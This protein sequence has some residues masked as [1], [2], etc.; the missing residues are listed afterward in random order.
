MSLT[1]SPYAAPLPESAVPE[2]LKTWVPWVMHGHEMLACPKAYN[3][4]PDSVQR[5]C[6]WPSL[7]KLDAD[8]NGATFRFDVQVF[9]APTWIILPGEPGLWPQEVRRKDATLAVAAKDQRPAVELP[10]GSHTITGRLPWTEMPQDIR[11]PSD[12]GLIELTIN[13]RIARRAPDPHGRV[14]LR[15]KPDSPQAND[16]VRVRT[17]RLIDDDIPMRVTTHYDISVS[18][19]PRALTLPAALLPEFVADS[20][21]SE[22]PARLQED[23][24][25][26]VQARA[27]NWTL[28]VRGRLMQPTVHLALP[29]GLP[30]EWWS[31]LA[32]NDLRVITAEGLTV[33]DPK[34]VPI[35]DAWRAFPTYQIKAGQAL[36]LIESRRGNPQPGADQLHL[37]RQIWLDF[38]GDGYTLQ[39]H[40]KGSL[41]RTWRLDMA[42]PGVLGRA[43]I[44]GEDQ[45]ITRLAD[46]EG[47]A[48]RRG[49]LEMSADSR[50]EHGVRRL[51]ATGWQTDFNAA[52]IQL[53]LPPGWRLLHASGV[54][55]AQGTWVAGWT[56]WDFFFV[57]LTA[58]AAGKLLG[59]NM[60]VLF[61][62]ALTLTWHMPGAP[63]AL[64]LTVLALI[65]LARVLPAGTL[66]TATTR[67]SKLFAAVLA[68]WLVPYGIDQIRIAIY[69][70]LEHPWQSVAA[71]LS[72]P[73][74]RLDADEEHAAV[75]SMAQER[76]APEPVLRKAQVPSSP[77]MA[78]LENRL[79][80]A[81]DTID[82]NTKIQTGPGLPGWRWNAYSLLWQGPVPSAQEI[83]LYLMPPAGSVL[84][85]IG[86]FIL[87]VASLWGLLTALPGW[88]RRQ[89]GASTTPTAPGAQ[90]VALMLGATTLA[91]AL[92]AAPTPVLAQTVPTEMPSP[93]LLD[94][95]RAKL[96]QPAD[97]LPQCADMTRLHVQT[98]GTQLQLRLETHVLALGQIPLPGQG[99]NWQPDSVHV[100]DRPATLRR[101]TAGILWAA[102]PAGVHQ[103]VMRADVHQAHSIDISLPMAVRA[104]SVQAPGWRVSGL[105]ARGLPSGALSLSRDRAAHETAARIEGMPSDALPPF[106]VIERV[107]HLGLRWT[108]QTRVYRAAP[109]RAPIIARIPLLKGEAVNSESVRTE[110]GVAI[111]QLGTAQSEQF[112]STVQEAEALE[113]VSGQDSHQ[114]EHW[115]LHPSAQ[116]HVAPS[117]IAPIRYIDPATNRLA[118]LWRPWPGER[119]TLTLR[120]PTGVDGQTLT[121]DQQNLSF[122]PGARATDVHSI[123]QLRT[124][125]GGNHE[126]H[127]PAD[128]T[129]LGVSLNGQA[130]PIQPQNGVLSIPVTPGAHTVQVHW[131]E[132]RGI[133][134]W[135][136]TS[137][138]KLGAAGVNAHTH[139]NVPRD[140]IVLAVSGPNIGPAVLFWGVL[141]A[142]IIIAIA[143]AR[144]RF[145]PLGTVAWFLLGIGVMQTSLV[146][147]AIVAGWFFALAARQ[148]FVPTLTALQTRWA[149]LTANLGQLV[150]V[151]WTLVA[152]AFL[153]DAIRVGLLGYP[154]MRVGG[155][156]SSAY[157]LN[158]YQDRFSDAPQTAGV[159]SAPVW[160]Y[161][162]LMLAW[163]L[164]L[165][166]ALLKWVRWAWG[167]F[168]A[169]GYWHTANRVRATTTD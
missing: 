56:L 167:C 44:D 80:N 107:L 73:K 94:E 12:T 148:R 84:L 142:L 113:W 7:L 19:N 126:V 92:L 165:S 39:D 1:A 161:R 3:S 17:A 32:H 163:A 162:L 2:P 38:D 139:I 79:P 13:G 143:L 105:D 23:G 55:Q 85:R 96:T 62:A 106:V 66:L 9:G 168:S 59:R 116:W 11:L 133:G 95:L 8:D 112:V 75:S 6:V 43:A 48:L 91:A 26:T 69:P 29:K 128:I 151:V 81:F 108:L 58:L 77:M 111:V 57:L 99:L 93:S 18:G 134:T 141:M 87:L 121:I 25:L 149:R 20:V 158:W 76:S 130:Q 86:G 60:G 132:P 54:D 103:I 131:R 50:I 34:Q 137:A 145:T 104:L 16:A 37:N 146:G 138:P 110:N 123:T 169:G 136:K 101:D 45:P 24:T 67:A 52:Q 33:V 22:L 61:A 157:L 159:V 72:A 156:G 98:H 74:A 46:S 88:T 51:P 27:G 153:L 109:S 5:A 124:S 10:P 125:Q 140:R 119:V 35:P 144:S 89:G 14:W 90:T 31:L 97:C 70:T 28:Q 160:V 102:V 15:A 65:A 53:N 4:A 40:I 82:P 135:F 68:L 42:P 49:T 21:S 164:W 100:N 129:F 117:G 63:H 152:A 64:W 166:A 147:A 122:T 41:S 120:K 36:K 155:N 114:I 150:L 118:L 30:D 115:Q 78:H 71:E 127:L 83:R 154:D 47:V